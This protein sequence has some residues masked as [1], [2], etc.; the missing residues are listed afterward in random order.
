MG[1]NFNGTQINQSPTISEKAGADVADIR[2]LIL[3]YDTDGNVVV[4]ADGTAPLLGVSIIEGGYNDISG[5]EAG[6]VKKGEDVD[7]LIKDIG[8][9]IASAEI[10][11][12][13]EVTATTGG[14]AA[15]AAFLF[16]ASHRSGHGGLHHA[17]GGAPGRRGLRRRHDQDHRRSNSE[18]VRSPEL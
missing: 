14:K 7:I 15:D 5:V 17:G 2:N 12:G 8:F 11:K 13:Q 9:V 4:A 3:K 6:K 10:K 16:P 1:K 18:R